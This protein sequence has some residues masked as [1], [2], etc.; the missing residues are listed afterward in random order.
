[1]GQPAGN[2]HGALRRH[3]PGSVFNFA[4]DDAMDR[5]KQ[6]RFPVVVPRRLLQ[7]LKIG[8]SVGRDERVRNLIDIRKPIATDIYIRQRPR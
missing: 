1:M 2:P 5:E 4:V 6:L 3:D 8:D 7:G